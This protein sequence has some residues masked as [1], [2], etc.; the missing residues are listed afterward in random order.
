[1]AHSAPP[2][3][4]P[5]APSAP[6]VFAV[7]GDVVTPTALVPDGAVVVAGDRIVWAGPLE[8]AP[9][10]GVGDAVRAAPEPAPGTH[11]LPGLVDLHDHG[12]GG[13]SFPDAT[14]YAE[15][16]IAVRQHR[17][18][19]TTTLLASLVTADRAVLLERAALLA[20]LADDGEI[21]GIHAEGPF[22]A[23]ERRG[24]H[25]PAHLLTGDVTLVR[26]L[27]EVSR[28]HLRTMTVAPDVEGVRGPGGVAD[29]LVRAGVIPSIGHTDASTDQ[30]EELI[31][32][33]V[34]A[35]A[36]A[37]GPSRRMTATH[38][39]NAMKPL[40]HRDA[41]P[42]PA[43]LAAARR[44]DL[45]VELIGDGVHL[46]PAVVRTV[47]QTVGVDQTV[48][49][50]DAMAA[51]GMSDGAYDLGPM[52]VAV[53]DGVARVVDAAHP[54]GGPIAG[55]TAHLV[56]VVRST[57]AA[58]VPLVAAVR[59]ASWVPAGVLGLDDVGGIVAGRRADLVVT[60]R[61]L[62]VH[63]VWRGGRRV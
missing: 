42:I 62:V 54:E 22:L 25:D 48:L 44:G 33:V 35:L 61:G 9:A 40:H 7:R 15:A 51:A 21:A 50:T 23:P 18:Q 3:E 4:P 52:S 34:A 55:G 63:E 30:A 47:V 41:G 57:V 49:V 36:A 31:A 17:S 32:Q 6:E 8:D 16:L 11:V 37:P 39:F 12:G 59:S 1:M 27:V 2:A 14:T 20:D 45:V 10:A 13:A 28:G 53:T 38:L 5:E 43:C 19:G 24:A 60:D 26:E 29:A 46:D 58:G 56:D